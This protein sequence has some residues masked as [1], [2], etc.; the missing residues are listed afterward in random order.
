[1]FCEKCGEKLKENSLFCEN[2][3]VEIKR[4]Q[5]TVNEIIPKKEKANFL[6]KNWSRLAVMILVTITVF[7]S[8]TI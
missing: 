4:E 2:C 1:M 7:P 3:G 5:K 8:L 6:Q